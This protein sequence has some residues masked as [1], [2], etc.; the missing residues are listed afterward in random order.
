MTGRLEHNIM[1]SGTHR[2]A[3]QL[4]RLVDHGAAD[5]GVPVASKAQVSVHVR[6]HVAQHDIGG[7]ADG[8]RSNGWVG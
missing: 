5:R 1:M 2:L 3:G 7:N 4:E 6:C 8:A